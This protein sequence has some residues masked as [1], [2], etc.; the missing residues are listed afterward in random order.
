MAFLQCIGLAIMLVLL[1]WAKKQKPGRFQ[2]QGLI[3]KIPIAILIGAYAAKQGI[4]LFDAYN[5]MVAMGGILFAEMLI[6]MIARRV[7]KIE[8]PG[9]SFEDFAQEIKSL[10]GASDDKKDSGDKPEA[11]AD[12]AEI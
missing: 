4:P 2:W 6:K 9:V 11:G 7:F 12:T 3:I 5:A 8:L 1:G 10:P